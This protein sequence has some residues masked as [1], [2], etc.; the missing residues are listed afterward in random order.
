M[1]YAIKTRSRWTEK[2][3]VSEVLQA[4]VEAIKGFDENAMINN[5]I[6]NDKVNKYNI[7]PFEEIVNLFKGIL[8][9]KEEEIA[10]LRAEILNLKSPSNEN[11]KGENYNIRKFNEA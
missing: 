9:S 10:K 8:S 3:K 2:K 11:K 1:R 4:S 6:L 7:R 5:N